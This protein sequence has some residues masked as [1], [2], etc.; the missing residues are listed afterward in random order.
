[1]AL[2]SGLTL[3]CPGT[4]RP[5]LSLAAFPQ[6]SSDRFSD[7]A[8]AKLLAIRWWDRPE[9]KIRTEAGPLTGP[10]EA[11]VDRHTGRRRRHW[12]V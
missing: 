2:S 3:W 9:E 11:F 1:M 6:R 5:L 7:E 10:I 4:C 8:I 12:R